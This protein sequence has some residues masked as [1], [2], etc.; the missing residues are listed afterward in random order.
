M[1]KV[2]IY[3]IQKRI[4]MINLAPKGLCSM[5]GIGKVSYLGKLQRT[6]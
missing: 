4:A 5:N 2:D 6:F 1:D 3:L